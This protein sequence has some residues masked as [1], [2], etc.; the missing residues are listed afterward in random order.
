MS[1][2]AADDRDRSA[3]DRDR[4]ADAQDQVSDAR[5]KRADERDERAE[6]REIEAGGVDA[7]AAADRGDASRDREDGAS[8]R[9]QAADDRE[10]ASADRDR[11]A[12]ERR[13]SSI[14]LLTGAQRREIGLMGLEREVVRS[15]RTGQPFT[16]AFVDVDNLKARN[17]SLGHAAGDQLLRDAA[18]CMR[19]HL[20]AYDLVVRYGGDEFLCG[21]LDLTIPEAARRFALVNADLG[22]M[23]GSITVGLAEREGEDSL[24]DLIAR[25]DAA[26][27]QER[28]R[29]RR[30]D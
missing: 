6:A 21:L 2:E 7:G 25:A 1:D 15:R 14:D 13:A 4:R 9:I 18:D 19:A 5:D 17:D 16:L 11:S 12:G 10:A 27:Y 8:N 20:R 30:G 26:L 23:Q 3:E 29:L 24:E 28:E 22:A